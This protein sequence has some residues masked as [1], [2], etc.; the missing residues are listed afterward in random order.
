M[1]CLAEMPINTQ[2]RETEKNTVIMYILK[3]IKSKLASE[4]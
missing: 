2:P 4:T 3:S 1:A